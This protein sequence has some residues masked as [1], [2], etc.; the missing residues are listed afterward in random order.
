MQRIQNLETVLEE[1]K[2]FESYQEK[3]L[4]KLRDERATQTDNTQ[5]VTENPELNA[6]LLSDFKKMIDIQLE[7]ISKLTKDVEEKEKIIKE[8]KVRIFYAL[9]Q[10][11]KSQNWN[12]TRNTNP[13][14]S[15]TKKY[16][17]LNS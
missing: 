2:K 15:Y 5:S 10:R 7:D 1:Y 8:Q 3:K 6:K 17:H 4:G 16:I 9:F 11:T 14:L 13:N 12:L